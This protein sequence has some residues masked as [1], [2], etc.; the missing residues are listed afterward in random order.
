MKLLLIAFACEPNRGSE[1]GVGWNWA[2]HI[3]KHLNVTVLTRSNNREIIEKEL[4]IGKYGNIHFI[5]YDIT[6]LSK[7]KKIIPFG[8][9]LY[10]LI[11]EL[12]CL[13]KINTIQFDLVQRITFVSAVSFI[14]GKKINKPYIY[15]F[16]GGGEKTPESVLLHYPNKYKLLEKLRAYYNSLYKYSSYVKQSINSSKCSIVVSEESRTLLKSLG[17][18]QKIH[19][20]PAIGIEKE[21][22]I[23]DDKIKTGEFVISYAGSLI[24]LKNVDIILSAI[25]KIEIGNHKVEIYGDGKEKKRLIKLAK[26]LDIFD[27]TF[28][29]GAVERSKLLNRIK[30]SNL[31]IFASS[32]DSGG[33]AVLEAIALNIPVLFLDTGGPSEIFRD[34]DYK[35][36]VSPNMQ[37]NEI[38]S[39]FTEKIEW[40]YNN[41]DS[42]MEIYQEIR[43]KILGRYLWEN[44]VAELIKIYEEVLDEN[45]SNT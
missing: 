15:G 5:Y 23:N 13:N 32:H 2:T 7:I 22:V 24:Y 33:F 28:F 11:W 42:F 8:T 39:S 6:L 37:Y 45:S 16:V 20:L 25:S 36:K 35:L 34:I 17:Y 19:L 30:I 38:V 43:K 4:R 21:I 44:K 10:F 31:F 1:P 41:Y 14:R 9:Q 3:S 26:E 18:K 40:V 12:L 27:K 29:N